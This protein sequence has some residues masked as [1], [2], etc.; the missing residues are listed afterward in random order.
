M[1]LWQSLGCGFL[2]AAAWLVFLGGAVVWFIVGSS[3]PQW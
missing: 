3:L 2:V 1:S